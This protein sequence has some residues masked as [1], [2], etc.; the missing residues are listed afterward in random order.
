MKPAYCKP[1]SFLGGSIK[2]VKMMT[3]ILRINIYLYVKAKN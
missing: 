3:K 1:V 2:C